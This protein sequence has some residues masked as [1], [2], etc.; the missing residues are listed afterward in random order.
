MNL[1]KLIFVDLETS[2]FDIERHQIIQISAVDCFTGEKFNR[3]V[4]FNIEF[5]NHRALEINHYSEQKSLWEKYGVTQKKAF[6][7][8][9]EWLSKRAYYTRTNKDGKDFNTSLIA[10]H[11][12]AC[13]DMTFLREWEC[14]FSDSLNIDYVFYDTLYLARWTLLQ[15]NSHS[16]ES[17]CKY[18]KIETKGLHDSMEDVLCNVKVAHRMLEDIG[19][20]HK[21]CQDLL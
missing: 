16:L 12:L 6:Y 1:D 21:W 15:L 13:F 8:F 10:G 9:Q 7:A 3:Y 4:R 14:M 20:T 5:A 18:Y 2:G 17:L 19:I 11:N